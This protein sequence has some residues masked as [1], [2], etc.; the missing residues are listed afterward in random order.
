MCDSIYLVERVLSILSLG[1][2]WKPLQ[3]LN[4]QHKRQASTRCS[5]PNHSPPSTEKWLAMCETNIH[6]FAQ[7]NWLG[8]WVS[9]CIRHSLCI[10]IDNNPHIQ[11]QLAASKQCTSKT[12]ISRL[13]LLWGTFAKH[14][15]RSNYTPERSRTHIR[16][17]D[18]LVMG[19]NW[20]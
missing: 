8:W 6:V 11:Q 18:K 20:K 17:A 5:S 16:G 15:R 7:L 3:L 13:C 9:G 19:S 1:T 14:T 2:V 10:C 4:C 12:Q